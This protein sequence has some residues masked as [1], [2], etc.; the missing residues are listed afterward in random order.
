MSRGAGA[1]R[2]RGDATPGELASPPTLH[3]CKSTRAQ[4]GGA[5]NRPTGIRGAGAEAEAPRAR[6]EA[7]R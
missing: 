5:M 6:N 3:L 4:G 1:P 7:K 2:V